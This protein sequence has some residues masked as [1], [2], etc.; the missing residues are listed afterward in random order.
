MG[1]GVRHDSRAELVCSRHSSKGDSYEAKA[2]YRYRYQGRSY[3]GHRISLDDIGELS[4]SRFR[5]SGYRQAQGSTALLCQSEKSGRSGFV[6]RLAV[7]VVPLL[8]R[9]YRG[10]RR[11]GDWPV[12][13]GVVH[14]VR[15]RGDWPVGPA[16]VPP[17][18]QANTASPRGGIP[19]S[20]GS[21][22]KSGPM[23]AFGARSPVWPGCCCSPESGTAFAPSRG[24]HFS[25]TGPAG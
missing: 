9:L 4:R 10:V 12:G 21:G 14:G 11:R 17:S 3:V 22:K 24:L 7:A 23:A 19:A 25:S 5:S 1:G 15:R 16:V 8:W 18:Q 20:R 13:P 6:P 2:E